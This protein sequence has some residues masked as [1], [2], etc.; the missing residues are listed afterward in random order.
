MK[1][2]RLVIFISGN[3]SNME[4]LIKAAA[5]PDFPAKI[6]GVI[7]DRVA[8][9]GLRKAATHHIATFVFERSAYQDKSQH[10]AA[11]MATLADLQPDFICLA[12]YMRLMSPEMVDTYYGRMLNIHPSLLPLFPGLDTHQRALDGG[13]KIAGCTVHLVSREMDQG[14]ILAQAAVPV[15]PTDSAETLAKRVLKAEH[16]LY[17]A[18]LA[19]FITKTQRKTDETQTIFSF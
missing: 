4:A 14:P 12:G 2:A 9:G 1:P 19:D 10:E 7:S 11:I 6:V 3:G 17:P 8:A 5:A 18:T 16:Q 13:V 15:L